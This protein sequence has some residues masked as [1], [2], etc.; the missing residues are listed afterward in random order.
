MSFLDTKEYNAENA[1]EKDVVGGGFKALTS[2]VYQ[3][4]ILLAYFSKSKGGAKAV[5]LE[6]KNTAT[7]TKHRFTVYV[8]NKEGSIKY[9]DKNTGELKYLPG[10]QSM[11]SLCLLAAGKPLVTLQEA[12]ETKTIN[13][14]N[15]DQKKE[16]PTDVPMLM[17]LLGKMI[18]AGVLEVIE[19]KKVKN[20]STGQFE[21]TNE[22]RNLNELDKFFRDR[23][24]MTVGEIM[25]KKAEPTFIK[26]WKEKWD[27]K[28]ND[29]FKA[30]AENGN[31]GIP[32][33][34][35]AGGATAGEPSST[36]ADQSDLFL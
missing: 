34:A 17:P 30:V 13:L 1:V 29:K 11:D 12:A 14:Y 31:A 21:P 9:K 5:N 20:Q 10:F 28:P 6:L 4:E 23:D 3:F 35:F 33:G 22:K 15:Y 36:T 32:G 25:A 27:G 18:K 24:D 26:E 8:S 7:N 16:V 19:N 2:A